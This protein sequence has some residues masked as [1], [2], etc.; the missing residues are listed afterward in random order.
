MVLESHH[1]TN[2]WEGTVYNNTAAAHTA[3]MTLACAR[4]IAVSGA[5]LPA[6]TPPS[7]P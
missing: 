6:A 4:S 2:G 5:A 3:E 7:T 1:I